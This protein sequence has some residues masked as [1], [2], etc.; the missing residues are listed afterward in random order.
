MDVPII[1]ALRFDMVLFTGVLG[2][3]LKE[4]DNGT[5]D[6]CVGSWGIWRCGVRCGMEKGDLV[7]A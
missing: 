6:G 1:R 4:L 2:S 5:E 3:R 7:G